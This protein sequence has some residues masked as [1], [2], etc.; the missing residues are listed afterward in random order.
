MNKEQFEE[1]MAAIETMLHEDPEYFA[2][3]CLIDIRNHLKDISDSL[4]AIAN[5]YVN[6]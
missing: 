1:R 4:A 3:K 6:R 2:T 5:H